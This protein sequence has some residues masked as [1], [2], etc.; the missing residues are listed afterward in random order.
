[1]RIRCALALGCLLTTIL[2]CEARINLALLEPSEIL[3]IDNGTVADQFLTS[4]P[5]LLELRNFVGVFQVATTETTDTAAFSL[6]LSKNPADVSSEVLGGLDAVG[7]FNSTP[8]NLTLQVECFDT[9]TVN[10]ALVLSVSPASLGDPPLTFVVKFAKECRRPST[11]F[12]STL[13]THQISPMTMPQAARMRAIFTALVR[14][15]LEF[16]I[17]MSFIMAKT[18][19]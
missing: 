16:A 9:A 17:V 3:I 6:V 19:R 15:L 4:N 14:T 12:G 18:V 8:S 5:V 7:T 13:F 10:Y 2:C 11:L 1:M